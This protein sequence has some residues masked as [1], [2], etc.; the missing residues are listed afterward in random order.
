[1]ADK[2]PKLAAVA[3]Q[4]VLG[5]FRRPASRSER[6]LDPSLLS[7]EK[8]GPLKLF[9]DRWQRMMTATYGQKRLLAVIDPPANG[10]QP[11]DFIR[12]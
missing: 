10:S 2:I 6:P 3:Q 5:R 12:N 4:A 9:Q 1:V 11:V 7:V 8:H